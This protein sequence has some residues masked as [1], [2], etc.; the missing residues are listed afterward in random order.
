MR[1]RR[2]YCALTAA[3]V[4]WQCSVWAADS[5]SGT[6][7]SGSAGSTSSMGTLILPHGP[8][9]KDLRQLRRDREEIRED[10]SNIRFDE[11][12]MQRDRQDTRAAE[13]EIKII[14]QNTVTD[15]VRISADRN[16]TSAARSDISTNRQEM[17]KEQQ[18]RQHLLNN[19]QQQTLGQQGVAGPNDNNGFFGPRGASSRASFGRQHEHSGNASTGNG[20]NSGHPGSAAQA[21]HRR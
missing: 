13:Y 11:R 15:Q 10:R 1:W 17:R 2:M 12:L 14:P 7:V 20:A 19:R 16:A 8:A 5:S 6:D 3:M 4:G 18:A 9:A 21:G